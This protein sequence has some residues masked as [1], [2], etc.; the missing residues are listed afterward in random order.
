MTLA[1][2]QQWLNAHGAKL[3]VDGKGGPATRAATLN[4]F[5]NKNALSIGIKDIQDFAVR[6]GGTVKQVN[7]VGLTESAGSGWN[8]QGQPKALYERHYFFKYWQHKISLL[9]DPTPGGYTIDS[10]HD[11]LNDSWEKLADAAML[12]PLYAFQ[13]ASFGK[14]QIMGAW[15]TKLNYANAIEFAY[16]MVGNERAHYEA[17]VRYIEVFGG[18]DKFRKLS[19]NPSDNTPFAEFY[20]GKNQKGYDTRLAQNMR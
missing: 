8:D 20:N 5:T 16:S 12:N 14:F 10:D 7:A 15:A 17:L 11:G 13:S 19:T 18:K 9:S 2:Y 4:I 6:L 1:E 3:V